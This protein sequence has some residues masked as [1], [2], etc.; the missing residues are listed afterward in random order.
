[1]Q[2]WTELRSIVLMGLPWNQPPSPNELFRMH[3]KLRSIQVPNLKLLPDLPSTVRSVIVAAY[4]VGRERTDDSD[5]GT[6]ATIYSKLAPTTPSLIELRLRG[7]L[8]FEREDED[9]TAVR[10]YHDR[11]IA[12]LRD[13]R[14][15][16]IPA[17][18][19]SSLPVALTPLNA[20]EELDISDLYH[21]SGAAVTSIEVVRLL[22]ETA[23]L[24]KL[25]L[26]RSIVEEWTD[27]GRGAVKEA[28]QQRKVELVDIDM[29]GA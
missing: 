28:A 19:V 8:E 10:G 20:L 1:M 18:A 6:P 23:T 17:F 29:W 21:T 3:T 5:T 12:L 25:R 13:V 2:A 22:S 7:N 16:A 15:L 14:H 26:A 4:A 11:L 9:S 24:R 27:E